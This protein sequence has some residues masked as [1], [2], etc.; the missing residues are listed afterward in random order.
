MLQ[1]I[2]SSPARGEVVRYILVGGF[3]TVFGY[4][5]F[6]AL[7]WFLFK[8]HIPASYIF[9]ALISNFLNITVA[10]L[11]YK[12]FVFR[13]TGNYLREW[14]KAIAV[15]TSS[16]LP[17]IVLLPVVVHLLTWLT[18]LGNRAPYV[19]T[20]IL[21]VFGVIYNFVGHKKF[22]FRKAANP[23]SAGD[24]TLEPPQPCDEQTAR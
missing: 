22:T 12:W 11:G 16:L 17:A 13:T 4:C 5:T 7:N 2:L 3:N 19:A 8:H 6:A 14:M 15:Y 24:S 23:P 18:P 1:R 20:A 21:T 10:F 9:A